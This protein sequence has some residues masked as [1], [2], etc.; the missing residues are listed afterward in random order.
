MHEL[1]AVLLMSLSKGRLTGTKHNVVDYATG[2]EA[3]HLF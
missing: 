1:I 3:A 2:Q